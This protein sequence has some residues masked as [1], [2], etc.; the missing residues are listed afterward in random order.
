MPRPK[1]RPQDRQRSVKACDACKASKKRCD[2]NQPCRLCL[3]KGTQDTCTYTPTARGKR[4]RYS[5]SVIPQPPAVAVV[6]ENVSTDANDPIQQPPRGPGYSSGSEI[7]QQPQTQGATED[8]DSETDDGP[9]PRN[10]VERSAQQRPLMLSSSSGAKVFVGNTAALSF[11]RFLQ[12]TLKLY[13]GPSGFTD[14]QHSHSW[15]ELAGPEASGEDFR[16]DL[17]EVEKNDLVRCFLEASSGFLDLYTQDELAGLVKLSVREANTETSRPKGLVDRAALASLYI[18]IAIGCQVRGNSRDELVRASIYFAA[19]RQMAFEKMLENPTVNLVRA[20]ILLAFYMC[21]ACR[22]NSAFMYLGVA[23]K[24]ADILGLHAA[25]Q[26]KHMSKEEQS[27]RLRVAKSVRVFDIICSSILGRRSSA[28]SLQTADITSGDVDQNLQVASHRSL[29]LRATYE[30]CSILETVI[31][32][33][34]DEGNLK[35]SSAEHYLQ[36][37]REWSQMLP[38][39]LRQRPGKAHDPRQEDYSSYREKMIANIHTAGS[40]YFGIICASRQF[41]IQHIMPRLRGN[42]SHFRKRRQHDTSEPPISSTETVIELSRACIG[43]ATLMAQM[44]QEAIDAG[45]FLGNMCIIKAWVFAAGLVLGFALLAD[46][47]DTDARD[48]FHSSRN[49]LSH[50]GR[51][52]PQADQYHKILSAFSDAIDNYRRQMRQESTRREH[53]GEGGALQFLPH[54]DR[55]SRAQSH[56]AAT[57]VD[58][59]AQIPTP[60]FDFDEFTTGEPEGWSGRDSLS[61]M[62]MSDFLPG[63]DLMFGILWDGYAMPFEPTR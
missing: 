16:D 42:S 38:V 12:K 60:D 2:A 56:E 39:A 9:D 54:M 24:S 15:F 37:L 34:A 11:L 14:G 22:R 19:G 57:G 51:L 7:S 59:A 10:S 4:S 52:S 48:A 62:S 6:N 5:H 63:N 26:H 27:T 58:A 55:Q 53:R 41:L 35:P 3:K 23:S 1:V 33:F 49:V 50:I 31:G 44:C 36:L 47:S 43:A 32:E 29:A 20:F 13:V 18:I 40:Y 25:T 28:P 45:V 21:G 8:A 46:D 30:S 17:G 61:A